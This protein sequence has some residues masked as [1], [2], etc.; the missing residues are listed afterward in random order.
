VARCRNILVVLNRWQDDKDFN[1][2]TRFRA[3]QLAQGP[4]PAGPARVRP[5]LTPGG[6]PR[7]G[8]AR[9]QPRP[10]TGERRWDACLLHEL[11]PVAYLQHWVVS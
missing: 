8:G 6:S 1:A 2:A 11:L 5:V 3:T 4:A 7:L 9:H 10:N